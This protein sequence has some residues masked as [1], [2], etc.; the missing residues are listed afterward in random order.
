MSDVPP[1]AASPQVK[2]E[3]PDTPSGVFRIVRADMHSVSVQTK[4]QWGAIGAV[5]LVVGGLLAWNLDAIKDAIVT[6][7]QAK[8]IAKGAS[9]KADR[10]AVRLESID[11]GTRVAV[12]QLRKE[13]ADDRANTNKQLTDMQITL[14]AVLREVKKK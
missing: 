9:D 1:P 4:V 5:V 14:Q 10:T 13:I 6:S 12:E 3:V 11:A 7:A 2:I 8:E